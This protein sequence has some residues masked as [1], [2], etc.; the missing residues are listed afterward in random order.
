ME[1]SNSNLA[2]VLIQRSNSKNEKIYLKTNILGNDINKNLQI[3]KLNLN[4][5]ILIK[6]L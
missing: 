1:Y 3:E 5:E 4:Q 2:L 6:K